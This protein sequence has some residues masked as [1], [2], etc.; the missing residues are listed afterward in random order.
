LEFCVLGPVAVV[1]QGREIVLGTTREAALLADLLLHA[2]EVVS[3]SRLIDD[4]WSGTPPPGATATLHSHVRNLR[5]VLEPSR[6]RG[7][8]SEVLL[9]Q[10][11]GYLLRVAPDDLDTWRS[12]RLI[13]EAR[14]SLADGDPAVARELLLAALACWRGPAFG[15][16]AT[17]EHLRTAAT[18]LDELRLSASE[19]RFAA[20]LA[21]GRHAEVCG[22]LES[23]VA[24]HPFRERLWEQWMLALYRSGRQADAL[25]AFQRV[26]RLL[27]DELGIEPGI[28]LRDL[29]EA[30][31]LQ[32]ADLAWIAEAPVDPQATGDVVLLARNLS[33]RSSFV[34]RDAEL[35]NLVDLLD[36]SDRR[37]VT[38]TGPAGVGKTR[39]AV[40]AAARAATSFDAGAWLVELGSVATREAVADVVL[41]ALGGKRQAGRSAEAALADLT[42]AGRWV[43]VLDNCEHVLDAAA[44]CAEAVTSVG[45]SAV[46]ATSRQPLANAGEQLFPVSG[47]DPDAAAELFAD[48]ARAVEPG[49]GLDDEN[50]SAVTAICA[51]LDRLPLAIELAAARVRA[52]STVELADR[53]GERFRLLHDNRRGTVE[54]HQTLHAAVRWSYDLL[55][56]EQQDVFDQLC[57]FAGG[58][59]SDAVSNVCGV[60]TS[61]DLDSVDVLDALVARSMVVADTRRPVTRYS[62]LETMREFGRAQMKI[63]G[64]AAALR[65]RHAQ[66]YLAVAEAARRRLS[67]PEGGSAMSTMAEEWD[68]LRVALDWMSTTNDAA[69]ALRLVVAAFWYAHENFQQE[70][71]E[72]GDRALALDPARLDELWPAAAGVTS[73]MRR[74]AGDFDGAREL[75]AEALRVE[76]ERGP[77]RRFLPA[78]AAW[79]AEWM[80]GDFERARELLGAVE[81]TATTKGDPVELARARYVRVITH[82]VTGLEALGTIPE[83]AIREAESTGV[84]FQLANAYTGMLAVESARDKAL[85]PRLFA[86]ARQWSELAGTR[87]LF[88]NAALWMALACREEEPLQTLAF[89]RLCVADTNARRY[90]GNFE[91]IIR[92]VVPALVRLGRHR[93]AA[94][95][96]GGLLGLAGGRNESI[97][98]ATE[99][100]PQLTEALGEELDSLFREGQQLDRS[101]LAQ[102][103]ISEVDSLTIAAVGVPQ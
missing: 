63:R 1:R 73:L 33:S 37:V 30:I 31:L 29:E 42:S 50:R 96:L 86:K 82:A 81:Q 102:L 65:D 35:T 6:N 7:G 44:S 55:E 9:T 26:R 76:R 75:A 89:A 77:T 27:D 40:H 34:G 88:D 23:M 21:L 64:N 56:P 66:H 15:E 85:A 57:V 10:R 70:L 28:G 97:A 74:S 71:L 68:N 20:E 32:K 47:L 13:G 3:T 49:F 67:T 93:S 72:W 101:S 91:L 5:R 12:E 14:R 90:W 11:P 79:S 61:G 99:L 48:R 4:L 94:V 84:P 98:L 8:P 51:G 46:L 25:H 78:L 103:A 80:A 17:A 45:A 22:E 59:L 69:S 39:L 95:L 43:V 87:I 24:Q 38:I 92:P 52:M 19:D 83:N 62:L 16:L 53:V 2:N 60:G 58:F 100:R 18:R 54:R 36:K 41:S